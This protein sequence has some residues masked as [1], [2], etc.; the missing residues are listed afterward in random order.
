[1]PQIEWSARIAALE[2]HA[3]LNLNQRTDRVIA[4][5]A[6]CLQAAFDAG[7]AASK[8]GTAESVMETAKLIR[9]YAP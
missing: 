2:L 6:V 8:I 7:I 5:F 4:Y 3:G 9:D 1:M